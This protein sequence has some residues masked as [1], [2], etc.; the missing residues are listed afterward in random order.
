MLN[1]NS[2]SILNRITD[3]LNF[4][5]ISTFITLGLSFTSEFNSYF[6]FLTVYDHRSF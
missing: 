1:G 6:A 2:D 4:S 5:R 3:D